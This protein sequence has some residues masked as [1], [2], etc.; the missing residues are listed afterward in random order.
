MSIV[1]CVCEVCTLNHIDLQGGKNGHPS[2]IMA[3]LFASSSALRAG[4]H[5]VNM[6]NSEAAN[7]VHYSY[8]SGI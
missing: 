4:E 2:N 1:D 8:T 6:L 5:Y 7:T 3:T